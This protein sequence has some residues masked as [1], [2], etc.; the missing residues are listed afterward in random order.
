[1]LAYTR[2]DSVRP[3]FAGRLYDVSPGG[4]VTFT[5]DF[6]SGSQ[7]ALMEQF[8]SAVRLYPRQQLRLVLKLELGWSSTHE[9]A[10]R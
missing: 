4:C 6:A 9:P 8:E 5:F 2:L 3:R 7:I 10:H 1:V